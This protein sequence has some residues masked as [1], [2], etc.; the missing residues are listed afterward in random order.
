[1]SVSL[2]L[3]TKKFD[4]ALVRFMDKSKKLP[5]Q[6]M[7]QQGKLLLRNIIAITPPNAGK[8]VSP[9]DGT[10]MIPVAGKKAGEVT[11]RADIMKVFIDADNTI[12]T[13]HG[14]KVLQS[15]DLM[16]YNNFRDK[17]NGRVPITNREKR[18]AHG[19]EDFIK[20]RQKLVGIAC[21][22]WAAG[23]EKCGL[24]IPKWMKH[25]Y[26]GS[27]SLTMSFESSVLHVINDIKFIGNFKGM[28]KRIQNAL[29]VQAINMNKQVNNLMRQNAKSSGIDVK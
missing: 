27:A 15:S 29:D 3:D 8:K 7:K 13:S 1:M 23:A 25:P 24:K 2:T 26:K 22:G 20:Q 6:V 9:D 21:G 14:S 10:K 16:F 12:D 17:N 4:A 18:L 11:I 5:S 28:Q 19:L